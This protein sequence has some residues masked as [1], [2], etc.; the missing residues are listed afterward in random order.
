MMIAPIGPTKPHAGV[1]ATKPATAPDAAPN[2]EGLPLN[3]HSVN[4]HA[5]VAAAVAIVVL[6]KASAA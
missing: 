5:K 4:D 1:I 3:A 2:I 6:T